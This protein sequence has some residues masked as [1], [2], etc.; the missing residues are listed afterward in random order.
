M[1][2]MFYAFECFHSA[3]VH[4]KYKYIKEGYVECTHTFVIG[5]SNFGSFPLELK[6][7]EIRTE[8]N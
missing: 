6:G 3:E 1:A 2:F 7:S 8:K 4:N 5:D